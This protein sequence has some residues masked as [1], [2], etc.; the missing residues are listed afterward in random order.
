MYRLTYLAGFLFIA[1]ILGFAIYL[2]QYHDLYPCPLCI[3]QRLIFA[4]TGVIFFIGTAFNLKKTGRIFVGSLGLVFSLLGIVFAGRHVWI[5]Y[6]SPGISD[7]SMGLKYLFKIMSV[8]EVI[9]KVFEGGVECSKIDWTFLHLSL[10]DWSLLSFILLF[11]ICVF[12]L[13]NVS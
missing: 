5:Q 11:I 1:V 8:N 9:A 4:V 7:C 2:Q 3:F 13:K 10:A 12:Q 6:F